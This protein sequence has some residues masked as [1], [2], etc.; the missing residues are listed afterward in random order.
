MPAMKSQDPKLTTTALIAN[1][2]LFLSTLGQNP[3]IRPGLMW[4]MVAALSLVA[5]VT[6]GSQEAYEVFVRDADVDLGSFGVWVLSLVVATLAGMIYLFVI[7]AGGIV[8]KGFLWFVP[9]SISIRLATSIW[10]IATIPTA[11]RTTALSALGLVAGIEAVGE[12]LRPVPFVDPVL[13]ATSGILYVALRKALRVDRRRAG[14][15]V[16]ALHTFN[17]LM[18]LV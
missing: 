15:V 2:T 1:P 8:L 14:T 3:S 9:Q 18:L 17:S 7:L 4:H 12:R 5:L 6:V 13:I 16:L 11:I 10:V